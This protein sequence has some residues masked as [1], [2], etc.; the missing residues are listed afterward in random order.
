[1]TGPTAAGGSNTPVYSTDMRGKAAT[2]EAPTVQVPNGQ[3]VAATITT[4]GGG[5]CGLLLNHDNTPYAAALLTQDAKDGHVYIHTVGDFTR[6]D[7]TPLPNTRGADA[8]TITLLPGNGVVQ[9]KTQTGP[10]GK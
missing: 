2:C 4:S 6:V 10:V 8:F 5:W 9:V 1:M 3:T 7:Y